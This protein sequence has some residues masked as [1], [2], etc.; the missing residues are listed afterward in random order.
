MSNYIV[1]QITLDDLHYSKLLKPLASDLSAFDPALAVPVPKSLPTYD[2]NI[3]L[4]LA[5]H[6]ISNNM[7]QILKDELA[8]LLGCYVDDA[9]DFDDLA[10]QFSE[11]LQTLPAEKCAQLLQAG[12]N[13][14]L[15]IKLH[16][17]IFATD[18]MKMVWGVR[19]FESIEVQGRTIKLYSR[20][21]VIGFVSAW[22]RKSHLNLT[23]E[24]I[25]S[26]CHHCA[27]IKYEHGAAVQTTKDDAQDLR[28]L[29]QS[30][31]GYTEAELA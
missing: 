3:L 9:D 21:S 15:N 2:E 14:F 20:S 17:A 26:G 4:A 22:G 16:G 7:D 13:A 28:R 27:V 12:L 23:A 11:V 30:L 8:D 6:I 24:M 10:E 18:W 25:D 31:L 19:E 29:A 1:T 5:H